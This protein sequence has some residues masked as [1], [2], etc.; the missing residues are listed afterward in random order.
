MHIKLMKIN[1]WISV[2]DIN[3]WIYYF[4]NKISVYSFISGT[5]ISLGS[6]SARGR[7]YFIFK[8]CSNTYVT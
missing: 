8:N 1:M 2:F 5:P 3:N 6:F 4:G 7:F